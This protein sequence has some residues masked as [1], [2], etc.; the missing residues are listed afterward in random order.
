LEFIVIILLFSVSLLYLTMI[1]IFIAGWRKISKPQPVTAI[2]KLPN[3]SVIVPFRN[4]EATLPLL[5]QSLEQ[6]IY[7]NFEVVL[8]DDWST[9]NSC[10]VIGRTMARDKRFRIVTIKH[11]AGKKNAQFE[12]ASNALS[13]Y[14]LFTDADC[15]MGP[16]W[17][18]SMIDCMLFE[19]ADLVSS[20]IE[21]ARSGSM[22]S[23]M[24]YLEFQSL[25]A[26]GAASI[27]LKRA[28]LC[29][30]ASL[31]VR[32]T[33]YQTESNK[34]G[35]N[36][37]SGDDI[38]LLHSIKKSGKIIFNTS[39]EAT[40]K[41]DAPVSIK[42]FVSQRV[43]WA[44]KSASYKDADSILQGFVLVMVNIALICSLIFSLSGFISWWICLA[45][46]LLKLIPDFIFLFNFLKTYNQQKYLWYFIPVEIIYPF[47]ITVIG[48]LS[49]IWH[50]VW[51]GRKIR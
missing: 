30:G 25:I 48:I 11:G 39:T 6:Q 24:M 9:D 7:P 49:L 14:L 31:A 32:K 16:F 4:E 35:Y 50:P 5:L 21:Y 10:E 28:S 44:S 45:I 18:R 13:D 47:Y 29:N 36:R 27:S 40:V 17:I 3:I 42:S 20:C 37:S 1:V 8:V 43:R 34:I 51:K 23:K 22:T 46:F 2:E 38:F 41:T 26:T 15:A 19:N 12:G 33:T